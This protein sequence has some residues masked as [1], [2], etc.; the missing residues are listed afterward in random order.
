MDRRVPERSEPATA[1]PTRTIDSLAL[2]AEGHGNRSGRKCQPGLKRDGVEA[3]AI[4]YQSFLFENSAVLIEKY[5]AQ[6]KVVQER[7]AHET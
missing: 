5:H 3:A 1:T 2:V 6:A 7:E 4:C